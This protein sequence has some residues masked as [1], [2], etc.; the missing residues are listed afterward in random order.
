VFDGTYAGENAKTC[1]VDSIVREI[2]RQPV[3]AFGNSSGDL[4]MQIY[5]ISG[6]PYKSVA[7]M[8][9]AD[10]EKREYGDAADAK[11]KKAEYQKQGIR[12]IS[13]KDD[14][15]TIYGDGVKKTH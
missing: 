5:T 10:D 11:T 1:K 14:F 8:V 7:F 6:N 13:M 12:I 2:G 4:A 15:K 9:M 3:L